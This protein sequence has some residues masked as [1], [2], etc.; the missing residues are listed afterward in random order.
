MPALNFIKTMAPKVESG[1]KR[2]TIRAMRK[3]GRNPKPGQ[4]LYLYTGMRTKSCRKL[5]EDVCKTVEPI[6]IDENKNTII[7]IHSL[8]FDEDKIFAKADGFENVADYYSFFEK[9]HDL[10]F[11]GVLI[12]W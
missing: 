12:K 3:D 4:T 8:D 1:E 9:T 2:Q 6:C 5:R 10:P 11:Y 7:G